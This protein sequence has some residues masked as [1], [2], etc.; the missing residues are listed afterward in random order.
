MFRTMAHG[1]CSI[2]TIKLVKE[3]KAG[4]EGGRR[5]KKKGRTDERKRGNEGRGC[6]GGM[7][8]HKCSRFKSQSLFLHTLRL[9]PEPNSENI[10]AF[11]IPSWNVPL[12]RHL[13]K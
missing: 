10:S 2:N 5:Q 6:G 13:I 8:S 11:E 9:G 12:A 4:R 1:R 3:G 7:D